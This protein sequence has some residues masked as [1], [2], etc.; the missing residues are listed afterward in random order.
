MALFRKRSDLPLAD[1]PATRFL[2]WITALTVYLGALA[3]AAA[4]VV[5][6]MAQRW[7]RGLA[8]GLTVQVTPLF[9][10]G[11][12]PV[13]E[14]VETALAILRGTPGVTRAEPLSAEATARLVEPWLGGGA[15]A[16]PFLPMPAVIDVAT[17]GTTDVPALA[18]RLNAAVPGATLDDHDAWLANLRTFARTV[19]MAVFGILAMI[20]AAGVLSVVFAVRAG[21]AIHRH[22]V[23]LLH[24]MGATDRYVARQFERHVLGLSLGGGIA[25]LGLAAATL[26]AV[27]KA[28][29]GLRATLLPD[30]ALQP[31]QWGALALVPLAA[32]LLAVLTARWTVLRTLGSMP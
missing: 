5:S 18:G 28:S 17:D 8:G 10:P 29:E 16:D 1:D 20:A 9:G 32:A 21:L 14:R 2:A 3:L 7:D 15:A 22:V 30:F 11:A 19:E 12:A 25:G 6:D 4:L 27:L 13:P 31:W 24:L 26:M 23:E